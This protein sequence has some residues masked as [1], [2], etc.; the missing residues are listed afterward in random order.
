MAK[1]FDKTWDEY[2]KAYAACKPEDFIAEM[3]QELDKRIAAYEA[4]TKK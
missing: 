2:M 3:Q 4:A 1:D